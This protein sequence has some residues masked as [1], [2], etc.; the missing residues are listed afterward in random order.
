MATRPTHSVTSSQH[1]SGAGQ[2]DRRGDDCGGNSSRSQLFPQLSL[3]PPN[4][5]TKLLNETDCS[6]AEQ[7]GDVSGSRMLLRGSHSCGDGVAPHSSPVV[8]SKAATHWPT[9]LKPLKGHLVASNG[10]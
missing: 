8:Q 1:A 4:T 3:H 7:L 5:N 10:E 2:V 9:A 6:Q